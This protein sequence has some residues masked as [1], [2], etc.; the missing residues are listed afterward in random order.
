MIAFEDIPTNFVASILTVHQ[1]E[2]T[3]IKYYIKLALDK[4]KGNRY[5]LYEK[6]SP[7]LNLSYFRIRKIAESLPREIDSEHLTCPC[8][9]EEFR[10]K[11]QAYWSYVDHKCNMMLLKSEDIYIVCSRKCS[12]NLTDPVK[13]LSERRFY[14]IENEVS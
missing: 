4:W 3:Q 11:P 13:G 2:I 12:E 6:L 8:C 14:Y 9:K 5:D 7:E 1:K 10:L